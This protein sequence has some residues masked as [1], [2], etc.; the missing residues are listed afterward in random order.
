MM[1]I[2]FF[3]M[4]LILLYKYINFFCHIPNP[5]MNKGTV[6]P[7][8]LKPRENNKLGQETR[9]EQVMYV[10]DCFVVMINRHTCE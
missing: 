6:A 7:G 1:I 10:V 3:L 5:I 2:Y 4:V 8:T 9:S